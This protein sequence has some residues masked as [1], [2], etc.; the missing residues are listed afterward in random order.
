MAQVVVRLTAAIV[1]VV[2]ELTTAARETVRDRP[3]AGPL[4]ASA[5]PATTGVSS[6]QQAG[7]LAKLSF[8]DRSLTV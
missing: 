5:E 6:G 8:L 3:E 2:A 4:V 7:G 1:D